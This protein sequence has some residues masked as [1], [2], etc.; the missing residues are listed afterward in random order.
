MKCSTELNFKR[1]TT[2]N[3]LANMYAALVLGQ[4]NIQV[5]LKNKDGKIKKENKIQHNTTQY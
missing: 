1:K 5:I 2:T 4:K 3:T